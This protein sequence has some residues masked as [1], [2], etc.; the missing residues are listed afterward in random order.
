M[1]QLAWVVRG[2]LA[3]L[4]SHKHSSAK[5]LLG[6]SYEDYLKLTSLKYREGERQEVIV[7]TSTKT[8]ILR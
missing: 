2:G 6:I 1:A 4:A 7:G 5:V 3:G 8:T